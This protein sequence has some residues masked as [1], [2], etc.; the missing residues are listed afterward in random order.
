MLLELLDA[1]G[2]EADPVLVS[3][4]TSTDGLD[5]R[6]P[7]PGHFHHVLVRARI[8]GEEYWLDGTFPAVVEGT[9][10]PAAKCPA[11]PRTCSRT[12]AKVP[13]DDKAA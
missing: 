9:S 4:G 1:L 10:E 8:A 7:N 3:N 6:L 2:I 5:A 12:D 13:G 11:C